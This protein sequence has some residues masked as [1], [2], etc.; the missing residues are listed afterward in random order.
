MAAN[1][2]GNE[3]SATKVFVRVRPFNQKERNL[4]AGNA[5]TTTAT[6]SSGS[7]GPTPSNMTGDRSGTPPPQ[8]AS[9]ALPI[10][11]LDSAGGASA[12]PLLCCVRVEESRPNLITTLDPSKQFSP[13]DTYVFERCFNSATKPVRTLEDATQGT[14]TEEERDE[15]GKEQDEVYRYV[16]RPVLENTLEGYNGCVFA[17]GQTGSGKTFTMMG[18][19]GLST[20]GGNRYGGAG[21]GGEPRTPRTPRAGKAAGGAAVAAATASAPNT[22][23]SGGAAVTV[24]GSSAAPLNGVPPLN[25]GSSSEEPLT[26]C[27]PGSITPVSCTTSRST[28]GTTHTLVIDDGAKREM[29]GI[30][31]RLTR[32]LFQHLHRKRELD[33]THSFRV[34]LE[35]Y[36]IYNERVIDLLPSSSGGSGAAPGSPL[37]GELRVRNSAHGP[38]IED[39]QRKHVEDEQQVLRWLRKGNAERHTAATKMNDR[40]SRSHAILVLHIAQ[41]R[42][43]DDGGEGGSVSRVT[44]KLNLVDLAGSE[45][46]GASGVAGQHFKEA[47]K[48]NLSLTALGRVIDALADL[49][50]GKHGVFCPYRDSNLT[51]LLMD[52]LG[53]NSKTTMVATVSPHAVNFDEI[54]QTLR[55]ASRA[56]QIVT[57]AIV[58]ED[59][60]VRQIKMLTAEVQR[61][62]RLLNGQVDPAGSDMDTVVD[63]LRDRIAQLEGELQDKDVEVQRLQA[64]LT[65]MRATRTKS[66]A[67]VANINT[68]DVAKLRAELQQVTEENAVLYCAQDELNRTLEK[69]Q[70]VERVLEV[71]RRAAEK[72]SKAHK[73]MMRKLEQE[74]KDLDKA[75][76]KLRKANEDL[77]AADAR[78]SA[79]VAQMSEMERARTAENG[80]AQTIIVTSPTDSSHGLSEA[81]LQQLREMGLLPQPQRAPPSQK[82]EADTNAKQSAGGGRRSASP[83]PTMPDGVEDTVRVDWA[84]LV[85][86]LLARVRSVPSGRFLIDVQ[87]GNAAT[88][89]ASGSFSGAPSSPEEAFVT[90]QLKEMQGTGRASAAPSDATSFSASGPTSPLVKGAVVGRKRG[91]TMAPV[92]AGTSTG[93]AEDKAMVKQV[94]ERTAA[95]DKY[96]TKADRDRD[97]LNQQLLEKMDAYR[98][99]Q[100]EVKR[101]KLELKVEKEQQQ[102]NERRLVAEHND[103]VR[104]L[105]MEIQD[106]NKTVKDLRRSHKEAMSEVQSAHAEEKAALQS[107]QDALKAKVDKLKEQQKYANIIE[108]HKEDLRQLDSTHRAHLLVQQDW[109]TASSELLY[110]SLEATEAA[111]H[112][113]AQSVQ[114][115]MQT[116]MAE[117]TAAVVEQASEAHAEE[118]RALEQQLASAVTAHAAVE[119]SLQHTVAEK[120]A[121]LEAEKKRVATLEAELEDSTATTER[122][123]RELD[124]AHSDA[125]EQEATAAEQLTEAEQRHKAELT[126]KAASHA[127]ALQAAQAAHAAAL[128]ASE[129]RE[130]S[131]REALQSELAQVQERL[132]QSQAEHATLAT[133]LAA[134]KAA[135]AA[136]TS[137]LSHEL[138][139]AEEAL[140]AAVSLNKEG[141]ACLTAERAE[142]E[143]RHL[144][145][146]DEG[147]AFQEV[148]RAAASSQAHHTHEREDALREKCA[149]LEGRLH[150]READ[151]QSHQEEAQKAS[152][153]H[154][155]EATDL[156]QEIASLRTQCAASDAA[157]Q[158]LQT[159][160]E[161]TQHKLD[162]EVADHA[163]LAARH[164]AAEETNAATISELRATVASLTAQLKGNESTAVEQSEAMRALEAKHA[165][166]REELDT[167]SAALHAKEA[168]LSASAASNV[169]TT[170]QAVHLATLLTQQQQKTLRQ[171][172]VGGRTRVTL[173]EKEAFLSLQ[174]KHSRAVLAIHSATHSVTQKDMHAIGS[175]L[176]Q[177]EE[178]LAQQRDEAAAAAAQHATKETALQKELQQ[179]QEQLA[180]EKQAVADLCAECAATED[181]LKAE[182]KKKAD[183]RDALANKTSEADGLAKAKQELTAQLAEVTASLS[184]KTVAE[185]RLTR[186]LQDIHEAVTKQAQDA[187]ASDAAHSQKLSKLHADLATANAALAASQQECAASKQHEAELLESLKESEEVSRSTAEE[188]RKSNDQQK[189][190]LAEMYDSWK[191]AI[192]AHKDDRTSWETER[193]KRETELKALREQVSTL[194][195]QGSSLEEELKTAQAT[196]QQLQ[197]ERAACTSLC[198][199]LEKAQSDAQKSAEASITANEHKLDE[200]MAACRE[201]V[202]RAVASEAAAQLQLVTMKEAHDKAARELASE[203]TTLVAKLKAAEQRV[204]E[205]STARAS[206]FQQH[207]KE[208]AELSASLQVAK[209]Q[210]AQLTETHELDTVELQAQHH[211]QL[212]E[213]RT[214]LETAQHTCAAQQRQLEDL[215]RQLDLQTAQYQALLGSKEKELTRL[216]D[217]LEFQANLDMCEVDT[218][219]AAMAAGG[220][221]GGGFGEEED[222]A[223]PRPSTGIGGVLSSLFTRRSSGASPMVPR[224][225]SGV[226][227][228]VSRSAPWAS[229]SFARP[230][231]ATGHV[232]STAGAPIMG[233]ARGSMPPSRNMSFSQDMASVLRRRSS[234]TPTMVPREQSVTSTAGATSLHDFLAASSSSAATGAAAAGGTPSTSGSPLS[235]R[236]TVGRPSAIPTGATV[237]ARSPGSSLASMSSP[238]RTSAQRPTT[239]E[240]I[241]AGSTAGSGNANS[242]PR[243]RPPSSSMPPTAPTRTRVSGGDGASTDPQR[244]QSS[245]SHPLDAS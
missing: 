6:G 49:S 183:L 128:Q 130:V 70:R 152:A 125:K 207:G 123:Q 239:R 195:R 132:S 196:C 14:I 83:P 65:S 86:A 206:Q 101:L 223:N 190:E 99:S 143:A 135:H 159:Q 37:S 95:L 76:E 149:A 198:T 226:S 11:G 237:S 141:Y 163:D 77:V 217:D 109:Q 121:A 184:A 78:E 120:S 20:T 39:L 17:Y 172:E 129:A 91:S 173:D 29:E 28:A 188:H 175:Q 57:K 164:A 220:V 137:A 194:Q 119:A 2:A 98:Q 148:I 165:E 10:G 35:Y 241:A 140:L 161:E 9:F 197:A 238:S 48:I 113:A 186:S 189:R 53:G 116:K 19:V 229:S 60:Q 178:E 154:E 166:Q 158:S 216:K 169:A 177:R 52:S 243:Q 208:V 107:T 204:A 228:T 136:E 50:Q 12:Y 122:L 230:A 205:V 100:M 27:S 84:A 88:T 222:S 212:D 31:P 151:L 16:G 63:E 51:W 69:L 219:N 80:A 225:T 133:E 85:D 71:E 46:T 15:L 193:T 211:V 74:G 26:A 66:A 126:E 4:S 112:E 41:M 232:T 67:V 105:D 127:E 203:T 102:V 106:L 168:E 181:R 170:K 62:Q 221:P 79:L 3:S 227:P 214:A 89:T 82:S 68:K 145:E 36:E 236:R 92:T 187:K 191:K 242:L 176:K 55:Y 61:L 56:K 150:E 244:R 34:E 117:A 96:K 90:K 5:T 234:V 124:H 245:A 115:E 138:H 23:S 103:R 13:K 33:S 182:Q 42:L 108:Q 210:L 235:V 47:T 224:R 54:C 218:A 24:T 144:L 147:A 58:N 199:A 171:E 94:K 64:E 139:E 104:R 231:G 32:D 146:R 162:R 157:L 87:A 72:E 18:P 30:I 209:E 110:A 81:T 134:L 21:G 179:A 38:Y 22:I 111:F 185:A 200:T 97:E 114:E 118:R 43:G 44:S 213:L 131:T 7:G 160:Q 156:Q 202:Q 25:L 233:G 45:R 73:A 59:P 215:Q 93:P 75:R 192:T 174:E 180:Q 142:A 8:T 40:S 167:V 1:S 153:A 240:T 155:A 201:E